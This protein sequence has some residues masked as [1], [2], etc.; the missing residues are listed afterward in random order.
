MTIVA[1]KVVVVSD[2]QKRIQ[3]CREVELLKSL[4]CDGESG[5][6][7]SELLVQLIAVFANPIDH[8]VS[9]CLEF[10][11]SG[12]LEDILQ[13]RPGSVSGPGSSRS[14]PYLDE[15]VLHGISA[16]VLQALAFLHSRRVIH[17]DLKPGNILINSQGMVKISDF[18]LSR[19]LQAG[20]SV[21][22]SFIGTYQVCAVLYCFEVLFCAS[23]EHFTL[24][25]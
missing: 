7:G 15:T 21:A 17:R 18:G 19:A 23:T 1:E 2:A 24:S 9:L 22:Q 11:N 16:Q 5:A 8:T 20:S 10:M 12:S 13:S 3:L 14:S 4:L 6:K 25:Q